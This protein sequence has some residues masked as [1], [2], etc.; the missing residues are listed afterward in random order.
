MNPL[1]LEKLVLQPLL[2]K[3][4]VARIDLLNRRGQTLAQ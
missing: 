4:A 2:F 3:A 1:R